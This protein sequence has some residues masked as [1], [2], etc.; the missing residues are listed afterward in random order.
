MRSHD[1]FLSYSKANK[2]LADALCHHLEGEGIRCWI[3]PRDVQPGEDWT[4]AITKAIQETAALVMLYTAESLESRHVKSE[5]RAAFDRGRI[6]IPVRVCDLAPVGGFNHLLGSSHWI[7]A[8]PDSL[9][10]YFPQVVSTLKRLL[11]G[12]QSGLPERGPS[13]GRR[14]G[15]GRPRR[16][17]RRPLV[18]AASGALLAVLVALVPDWGKPEDPSASG[19]AEPEARDPVVETEAPEIEV[20]PP[21]QD[22]GPRDVEVATPVDESLEDML[23]R[24]T[25]A[26]SD[27]LVGTEGLIRMSP[28][29]PLDWKGNVEASYPGNDWV[30]TFGNI[31]P[32]YSFTI[33]M[34]VDGYKVYP[35]IDEEVGKTFGAWRSPE[36]VD[37]EDYLRWTDME[38][39]KDGSRLVCSAGFHDFG[40]DGSPEVVVA[41]GYAKK[42]GSSRIFSYTSLQVWSFH[43][44]REAANLG[45]RENWE[46]L[47]H[48]DFQS[49]VWV[50][51]RQITTP[52]GSRDGWRYTLVDG[53]FVK[54]GVWRDPNGRYTPH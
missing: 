34:R 49:K 4:D 6:I 17:S 53:R 28:E 30:L 16:W 29:H 24:V 8:F 13:A 32:N 50:H 48:T 25:P 23:A 9:P 54:A 38:P 7:D 26:D 19:S 5:V 39:L 21:Q 2:V 11:S 18:L 15:E 51:G 45:R 22:A 10:A 27:V 42:S 31:P 44:P 20:E 14:S 33:E 3:A 43:P 40:A 41:L 12:E 47:L 36:T 35:P 52:I 37:W 1:V 46:L